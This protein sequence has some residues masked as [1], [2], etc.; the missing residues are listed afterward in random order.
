MAGGVPNNYQ[1]NTS[2]NIEPK[3]DENGEKCY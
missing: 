1:N 2:Q 3:I